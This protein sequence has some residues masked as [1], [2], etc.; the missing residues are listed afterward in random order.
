M[1]TIWSSRARKRSF[2][3]LS[4][5]SFGRIES[6]PPADERRRNHV[7]RRHAIC[8]IA[9]AITVSSG[10]HEDLQNSLNARKQRR[11]RD[12]HRRQKRHHPPIDTSDHGAVREN[13]APGKPRSST[14][15]V[16]PRGDTCV[17]QAARGES[18]WTRRPGIGSAD[19]SRSKG[20]WSHSSPTDQAY[21]LCSRA[22]RFCLPGSNSQVA[23][24]C[25]FL[26][27]LIPDQALAGVDPH[28]G[29][30]FSRLRIQRPV[31]E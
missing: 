25:S 31:G 11:L 30:P 14:R 1:S 27:R 18:R 13:R 3:P 15:L 20:S 19:W 24:F 2:C 28:R 17:R 7:Q 6:P 22:P 4:R 23:L 26:L 8:K 29:P 16:S 5:C 10:K 21:C 12:L 9:A